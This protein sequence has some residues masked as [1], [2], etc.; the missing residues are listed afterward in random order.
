MVCTYDHAFPFIVP[1]NGNSNPGGFKYEPTLTHD[2]EEVHDTLFTMADSSTDCGV[3]SMTHDVPVPA[4]ASLVVAPDDIAEPA[5]MQET[6]TAP[7]DHFFERAPHLVPPILRSI[8][9]LGLPKCNRSRYPAPMDLVA[10]S[11]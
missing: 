5:R 11:T 10:D 8:R 1:T 9:C 7:R 6:T 2:V 3:F 4:R